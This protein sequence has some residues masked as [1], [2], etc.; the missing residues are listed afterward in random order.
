MRVSRVRLAG[1]QHASEQ[2]TQPTVSE[3][4]SI[5]GPERAPRLIAQA[6]DAGNRAA[7]SAREQLWQAVSSTGTAAVAAQ[8]WHPLVAPTLVQPRCLSALAALTS[9]LSVAAPDLLRTMPVPD[10]LAEI[11]P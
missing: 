7:R 9:R 11:S 3:R 10:Q 5:R 1:E 4:G 6:H 2:E 8:V